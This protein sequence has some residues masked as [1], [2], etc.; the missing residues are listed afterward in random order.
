MATDRLLTP[1]E[2][3]ARL[4]ISNRGLLRLRLEGRIGYTPIGTG[5]NP[6]VYYTEDDIEEFIRNERRAPKAAKTPRRKAS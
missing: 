5:E 1:T 4:R 3:A 2:T 6:R